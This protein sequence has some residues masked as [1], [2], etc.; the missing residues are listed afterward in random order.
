MP[1]L[2]RALA[3]AAEAD[4]ALGAAAPAQDQASAPVP[5]PAPWTEPARYTTRE[6]RAVRLARLDAADRGL[7]D[8]FPPGLRDALDDDYDLSRE[9]DDVLGTGAYYADPEAR[10]D[11]EDTLLAACEP[12]RDLMRLARTSGIR[13]STLE[14]ARAL[15][16]DAV[17]ARLDAARAADAA[18]WTTHAAGP[19]LLYQG[20]G[21]WA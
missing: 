10:D 8:P 4:R 21:R 3:L 20:G 2:T 18:A 15:G 6:E 13:L 12:W 17:R 11:A 9:L 5:A 16:E 7:P 1:E 14:A 19:R